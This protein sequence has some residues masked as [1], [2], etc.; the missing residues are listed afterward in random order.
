MLS[1]RLQVA[2]VESVGQVKL[3]RNTHLINATKL[4]HNCFLIRLSPLHYRTNL[5]SFGLLVRR[6]NGGGDFQGEK[7]IN[8]R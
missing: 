6:R 3:A 5:L 8:T 2:G 7:M 1:D 4:Q